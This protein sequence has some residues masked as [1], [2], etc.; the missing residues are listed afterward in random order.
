LG[1][2]FIRASDALDVCLLDGATRGVCALTGPRY[3]RKKDANHNSIQSM[4]SPLQFVM[5][6]SAF[7]DDWP[8]IIVIHRGRVLFLEVKRD[9]K[10]KMRK[11][12]AVLRDR[13]IAAGGDYRRVD[14]EDQ[15]IDIVQE[16]MMRDY[17]RHIVSVIDGEDE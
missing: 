8:D 7:G 3:A 10:A 5:D 16:M 4:L 17:V 15:A 13:I 6:C 2:D 9:G 11:G 12:Q 14:S 1:C